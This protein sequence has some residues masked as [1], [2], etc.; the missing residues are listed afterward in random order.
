MRYSMSDGRFFPAVIITAVICGILIYA[1][2][3]H[4]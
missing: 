2:F 4:L 3:L 1:A